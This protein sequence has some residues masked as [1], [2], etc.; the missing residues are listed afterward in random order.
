MQKWKD[1]WN[2]S[3]RVN[4]I[5]LEMLIKAD[6]FDSGAGSFSVDDWID[7]TNDF[8]NKLNIKKTDSIFD[9]GCGSGAFVYPLYLKNHNVGGQ[10]TL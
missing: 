6:G 2:K 5:I 4:K 3:E 8:Y 10:I 9:V 7:Y 1:I